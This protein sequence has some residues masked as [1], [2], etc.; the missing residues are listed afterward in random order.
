MKHLI[1]AIAMA[2]S[3][4]AAGRAAADAVEA[5]AIVDKA[6]ASI[7]TL[8]IDPN[9]PAFKGYAAKAKGILIVPTMIK[10]GFII[11]GSG[12]SGVLLIRQA[13]GKSFS[14]PAFYTLGSVTFGL[15]IGG[16]VSELAL[17]LMT[18]DAVD[19]FLTTSVKLGGDVSVAAG[20]VGIGAKAQIVDVWAFSRTQGLYGGLNVE[21]AVVDVRDQWNQEYYGIAVRPRDILI[22]QTVM[23]EHAQALRDA[24]A[25]AAAPAT[26]K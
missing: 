20:P 2:A 8:A 12:G 26:P 25:Q 11:G 3:L 1:A 9:L 7:S 4:F 15:Q 19:S 10:A 6:K 13:D 16:E 5:Q 24:V 14:P 23:N 18:D 17:L 21:G 22:K